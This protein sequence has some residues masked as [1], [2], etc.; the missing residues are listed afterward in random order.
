MYDLLIKNANVVT[1]EGVFFL[2]VAILDGKIIKLEKDITENA[3]EYID[4]DSK[5]LLPGVIDC[6]VHFREPGGTE[7]EDIESGSRAAV[8]GGVT[9]VLDMPNTNP[10]TTTQEVLDQKIEIAKKKSYC[11]IGFFLGATS[12]NLN[13]LNEIKGYKAIKVYAGS[14][15]GDLLL[16]KESDQSKLLEITEKIVCVHAEDEDLI[17]QAKEFYKDDLE[18]EV[19]SCIRHRECAIKS[20]EK[21]I[22]LAKKYN[23]HVHICHVSTEEELELIKKAKKE[24]IKIT[25]EVAPHHLFLN[26]EYYESMGNMIKINPPVRSK[27]DN[28]ALFEGLIDGTIDMIATDHAPHTK[29]EKKKDYEKA[30]SGVPEIEHSLSLMLNEVSEEKIKIE[31]LV[32][33]MSKNPATVFDIKR[34]GEVG[35]GFDADMVIVDLNMKVEIKN[36]NVVSKCGWSP[37]DKWTVVGGVVMTFVM[38]EKVFDKGKLCKSKNKVIIK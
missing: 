28:E 23:K 4:A 22:A 5:Y 9:T 7:K 1:P 25:C 21:L 32:E 11:N 36:K 29:E 24:N 34:K 27:A 15:T 14:S 10:A 2:D 17:N 26:D 38:G 30:P 33:I 19:H 3:K 35:E 37:Y 16:D 8:S 6:H 31:K 12:K 18:P 20:V 13:S